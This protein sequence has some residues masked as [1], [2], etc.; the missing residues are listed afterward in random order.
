MSWNIECINIGSTAWN[1]SVAAVAL[2]SKFGFDT[3]LP[4]SSLCRGS[5]FCLLWIELL[6]RE[7]SPGLASDPRF[8]HVYREEHGA[9]DLV[10]APQQPVGHGEYFAACIAAQGR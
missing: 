10:V 8:N 1:M 7:W 9:A 2:S 3:Y 6:L 4:L 5:I